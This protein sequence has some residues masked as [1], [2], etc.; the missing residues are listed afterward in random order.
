MSFDFFPEKPEVNPRIYAYEDT[1]PQYKNLIKIGFTN[2]SVK[3]RVREQY[4]TIRPGKSPFKI[5]LDESAMRNDG[6]TFYDHDVFKYLKK[7]KFKN[8]A[9]E[10]F[11]CNVKNVKAAILALKN[12][13]EN[14]SQRIYDFKMRPEQILAVKKTSNYF[15]IAKRDNKKKTPHF[16]WNAK[17][18]FGKTFATYQLAKKENWKRILI[19]TFKPAVEHAWEE[20]L[21]FH[22][23]FEGWQ[24]VSKKSLKI[25]N[26]DKKKPIVC[27][28]SFQDYL[29]KNKAGG[30]KPKNEWVHTINWDCVI[31]DEYHFGAWREN[32]KELVGI[33]GKAEA[34]F[35]G[36]E[37]IEYF[38]ESLMPITTNSYLY[39]SGT[40]FRA[41]ETGEFI[42]SQI[43]NWT[44]SDEQESKLKWR[45]KD[46]PYKSLPRMIL[47][48][49][50]LPKSITKII[51][52]K[53]EFDE[54]DLNHF[55]LAK[56]LNQNAYF[57]YEDEVQK[58]LEF[59]RG[60]L[61]ENEYDDLKKGKKIPLFPFKYNKLKS[62][63][64]HTLWF[65]P[66]VSSCFAMK[67]LL[68]QRQNIFF[69]DFKIN[70]AAGTK[71]GIGVNALPPILKS[72]ENPI[73]SK[74]ITL[75]CGKLTQGV[76]VKPWTGIFMLRNT[77]TP[78]TYFQSAFRVQTPWTIKNESGDNP[79]EE[80]ILK[81]ECYIF[82]FAPNRSLKLINDY[83]S[84]LNTKDENPETKINE[85][86]N[87]LPV[88]CYDGSSMK[89]I[90]ASEILNIVMS[91]TTATLLA[92]KWDSP[93]IVHVD[94]ETLSRLMDNKQAIDAL[95]NIEGFRNIR[96]DI[97]AIIN[98]SEKIKKTKD[99]A[100]KKDLSKSEKKE[101]SDDEKEYRNL[102][103][104]VREKLLQ[105]ATRIPVFMY[106]TDYREKTLKDVITKIEPDLFQ[107]VTGLKIIDFE[108]L[109]S[110]GV[111][112]A[113]LMNDA[114]YKFKRYEDSSLAYMGFVINKE[115]RIGLFDTVIKKKEASRFF[116]DNR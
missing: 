73:H 89:E 15:R 17:M 92:R 5:I 94:N 24:F 1:N 55:F 53:G 13:Q 102:R 18:R 29:G 67:N 60:S 77:T 19:L 84:K 107:K 59:I 108:R 88:L 52:K 74:T 85:I 76:S 110:L 112:D 8:P 31:L 103:K 63:L 68:E 50:Q 62:N 81:N 6:T 104:K 49:Y 90:D 40:P 4:P 46:N 79:N 44:Y 99:S 101:L 47:M 114:I 78:E 45:G 116:Y 93:S 35:A 37:G 14:E 65:L 54:F 57:E 64:N 87:F 115:N 39:L 71:A 32:A 42:E 61:K 111:F 3:E 109:L 91:G 70:V 41:L 56:G 36:G 38:D 66:S 98:K 105:F 21:L 51:E 30:I 113:P 43:F 95:M 58:W 10:W 83:A 80:A 20:D 82:D 25:K 96:Q 34:N 11:R 69:R 9:G 28:G 75:T 23:D 72:M 22:K 106:L 33:E 2:R 48:T 12:R 7:R 26:T 97:E 86:I 100:N 16:L 27:F